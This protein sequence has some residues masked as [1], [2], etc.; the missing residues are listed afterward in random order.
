MRALDPATV[1]AANSPGGLT[2]VTAEGDDRKAPGVP[3]ATPT[4]PRVDAEELDK[5]RL[6]N[7]LEL[8]KPLLINSDSSAYAL[9][10]RISQMVISLYYLIEDR[11]EEKKRQLVKGFC[12]FI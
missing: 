6:F 1:N 5:D 7:S 10:S 3:A 11:E 2:S 12:L 9:L 4:G 8:D